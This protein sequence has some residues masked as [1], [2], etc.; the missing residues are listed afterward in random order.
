MKEKSVKEKLKFV[1]KFA[2]PHKWKFAVMQLCMILASVTLLILPYIIGWLIDEVLDSQNMSRF[3]YIVAVYGGVYI[4]NQAMYTVVNIM[5]KVISTAFLF[6]IRAELYARILNFKGRYLTSIYSGDMISRMGYDVDQLMTMISINLFGLVSNVLNLVIAL[7][8]ILH[9]NIW[10]GA[11]TVLVTPV[12][13]YVSRFFFGKTK[14]GNSQIIKKKGLLS[15]WLYEILGGMQEIK[16]L[17]A[18]KQVISEFLR[19]SIKI[20]RLSIDLNRTEVLAE[21]INAGISLAAQMG[22]FAIA[23]LLVMNRHLTIGGGTACFAY[24]TTCITAFNSIN[25][26]ILS[27]SSNLASCERVMELFEIDLEDGRE[28]HFKQQVISGP[29]NSGKRILGSIE[30]KNVSFYYNKEQNIFKNLSF[31][32]SPREKIAIVGHSGVGKSTLVNLLCRI[33]DVNSGTIFIDNKDIAEYDIKY[34]RNQIGVVHQSS[35]IFN[36]SIRFNLQFT[37]DKGQDPYL[38][39]ALKMV[40]LFDFVKGLEA[41]LDTIVGSGGLSFSGGQKQRIAIARTFVKKSPIMIFDESTSSLDSESEQTIQNS[42]EILGKN[43]TL[44]IIAHRLSTIIH[45][46]RIL[47]FEDG[48]VAGFGRHEALLASCGTYKALFQEQYL[49]EME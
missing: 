10:L 27:L 46:D 29:E 13:I 30:F 20:A 44:L 23:A 15:S 35:I 47:V 39:E 42:W 8:F 32:I 49:R 41:G 14:S 12:I 3:I 37:E 22:L 26:K 4:F 40:D 19:R 11:F 24:Y 31:H 2:A 43:H 36:G 34:L 48:K 9:S 45:A 17:H 28:E 38:W 16:L 18:S 25:S 7:A 5:E 33:Y 1:L 6:D 21:R